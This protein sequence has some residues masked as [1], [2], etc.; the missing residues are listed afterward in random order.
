MDDVEARASSALSFGATTGANEDKYRY[1]NAFERM[2]RHKLSMKRQRRT[3]AIE[4]LIDNEDGRRLDCLQDDDLPVIVGRIIQHNATAVDKLPVL[5]KR[6]DTLNKE[7]EAAGQERVRL[8]KK[9]DGLEWRLR[10][11]T[12]EKKM[13]K[14]RMQRVLEDSVSQVEMQNQFTSRLELELEQVK[15]TVRRE[16]AHLNSLR[17]QLSDSLRENGQV[18]GEDMDLQDLVSI[19]SSALRLDP[20]G[21]STGVPVRAHNAL[22]HEVF[23]YLLLHL[24]SAIQMGQKGKSEAFPL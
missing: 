12:E 19:A 15:S 4:L 8:L 7:L 5:A 1:S 23:V 17:Q 3:P 18:P 14:E 10:H 22:G 13:E 20:K 2:R 11:F 6:I 21:R 16:D 9:V 24:S